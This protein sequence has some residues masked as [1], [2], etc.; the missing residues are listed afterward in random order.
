MPQENKSRYAILGLLS[1][2]SMSGYELRKMV[3]QSTHSFWHEHFSQIYPMLKQ[4]EAEGL[5]VS[6]AEQQERRP[7]RHVYTLTEQGWEALRRWLEVPPV[8]QVERNER[9]LKLFFGGQTTPD[10]IVR[11]LQ[12][13][14][15]EVLQDIA[16]LEQQE[17]VLREQYA[18]SPHLPYWLMTTS[19]G[20]H[21]EHAHVA[22]CEEL[23]AQFASDE[24]EDTEGAEKE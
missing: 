15:E 6:R 2:Q 7:E 20:L 10:V 8:S 16:A 23:L 4:L 11:H 22:W 5:T 21:V 24:L 14:R 1:L 13:F 3:E 18:G 19:Y 9:L 12:L 17:Q